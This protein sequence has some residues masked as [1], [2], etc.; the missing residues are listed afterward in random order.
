MK[1]LRV[2]LPE[3]YEIDKENSIFECIKFKPKG[4]KTRNDLCEASQNSNEVKVSGYR[5]WDC[6]SNIYVT[7]KLI[8]NDYSRNVFLT[9]K[10]AK[11]ALAMAQISQLMP[12][13]GGAITDEEWLDSHTAKYAITRYEGQSSLDTTILWHQFLSFHTEEQRDSFY[14]NNE[15]LVKEYLMID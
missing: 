5:I 3:G 1:E 2:E 7:K 15:Q 13:Y 4:I 11:S 8:A 10:E 12:Y 6:Y 9:K 14:K